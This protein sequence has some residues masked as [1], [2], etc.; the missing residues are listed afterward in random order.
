[1]R[2]GGIGLI[3]LAA[4]C[5]QE[6]PRFTF[7]LG[8]GFSSTVGNTGRQFNPT[9]WNVGAS[10]GYNFNPWIGAK[11]DLGYDRFS[12]NPFQLNNLGAP[13][14]YTGIFSATLDPVVHLNPKGHFDVYLTGGGGIFHTYQQPGQPSN[15]GVTGVNP[16]FGFYPGANGLIAGSSYAVTKPGLDV[17]AGIAC[18][19]RFHGKIFAEA[20]YDR[21]FFNDHHVD[22]LPITFGFRW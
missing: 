8:T 2:A 12:V 20:K 17:G 18:G 4:S 1:M 10:L 7:D 21:I 6:S 11:V 16:F 13:N 15:G 14:G 3:C 9:G 22:Y 19:T 5:G